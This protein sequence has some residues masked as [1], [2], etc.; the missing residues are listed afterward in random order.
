M[1]FRNVISVLFHKSGGP[2]LGH[3]KGSNSSKTFEIIS[4]EEYFPLIKFRQFLSKSVICRNNTFKGNICFMYQVIK[5]IY[6]ATD[7]KSST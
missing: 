1:G 3:Y 2:V 4:I 5:L 6:C 7:L